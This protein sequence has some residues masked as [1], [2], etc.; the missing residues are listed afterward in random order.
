MTLDKE[1]KTKRKM[2]PGGGKGKGNSFEN[3]IAKKLSAA[4]A[5][6]A[7]MR[8]PGSGAR[9]GG[10]NFAKFGAMF[11]EEA[12]NMFSADVVTLNEKEVGTKFRFSIECK[13]YATTDNFTGLA[14][15]SANIFKWFEESAIDA[16]KTN[17]IPLLICKWNRTPTYVILEKS[18]LLT[19]V[20]PLLTM[21]TY[22]ASPRALD[23]FD[24]EALLQ[25]RPF[26]CVAPKG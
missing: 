9:L 6:L 20:K 18:E 25:E 16:L 11:G 1:V 5:P 8:S 26:W 13:S 12:T 2:K 17:K 3:T 24:L 4:L 7:F 21:L 19:N 22:G 23:V 14:S 15:G 10:K